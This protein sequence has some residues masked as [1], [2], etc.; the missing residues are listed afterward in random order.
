METTAGPTH[1]VTGWVMSVVVLQHIKTPDY[2]FTDNV[3]AI[4]H[5]YS[6]NTKMLD[7][8]LLSGPPDVLE[9][10]IAKLIGVIDSNIFEEQRQIFQMVQAYDKK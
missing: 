1:T 8:Y 10:E 6:H 2:F 3:K 4:A 5:L 9:Q 7:H